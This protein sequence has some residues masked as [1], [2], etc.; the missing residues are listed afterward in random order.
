MPRLTDDQ[1]AT[2]LQ[3]LRGWSVVNNQLKKT[4][5]FERYAD[6]ALFAFACAWLAELKDHHPD[7][8]LTYKKVQVS[9][10]THSEEGITEKDVEMARMIEDRLSPK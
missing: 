7:L 5:A 2:A 9:L 4:Y 6:A 1:I 3:T 8:L 10:Y